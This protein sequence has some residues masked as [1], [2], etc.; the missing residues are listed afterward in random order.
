MPADTPRLTD[1]SLDALAAA[2]GASHVVTDPSR[3]EVHSTDWTGR[4]HGQTP[5]VVRPG[6]TDEVAAVLAHCHDEHLAVVPQGG[7]TGLVGGG[8]PHRGEIVL[9]LRRLDHVGPV[10]PLARQVTVGAGVTVAALGAAVAPHGLT[11]AVD[12]AARDT[13]TIGGTI[14]TNAGGEHVLRWG[15]TRAQVAGIEAVLADGRVLRHL[16]GLAKDNT[17]YDLAGLLCGSEGTLAVVTAARLRLVPDESDRCVALVGFGSVADAVA[18]VSRLA[19]IVPGL[20]AAE[21]MLAEGVALVCRT[22]DRR[23]PL[24]PAD[25][26]VVLVEARA[27]VEGAAA[28]ALG[29]ALAA[30]RGV[31]ATVVAP[32]AA[33]A[34]AL[35]AYRRDHTLAI[36]TLGPPHKLDVTLPLTE[37]AGFVAEVPDQVRKAAPDAEVWQFGHLGDGNIHVNVTGLDPDDERVDEVV[38]RLAARCGGSISAEHGIGTAKRRWLELNRSTAEIEVFAAIKHAFDP[39][40][41]LNPGVLIPPASPP[42]PTRA[43]GRDRPAPP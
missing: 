12:F 9:D 6:S 10:D 42:T 39:R 19:V 13:A 35:W 3:T 26:A 16:A 25:A 18:A 40:G 15:T 11:Y 41:V 28:E 20:T 38:L 8:V 22:F 32:D 27:D 23:P 1:R 7:N 37:L 43:T 29:R 14:A 2:V 30:D 21:L 34:E 31:S 24:S 17:G 36:N 4:F 33:G 5:A